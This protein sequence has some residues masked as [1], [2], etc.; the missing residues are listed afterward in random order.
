LRRRELCSTDFGGIAVASLRTEVCE[1]VRG[2]ENEP[3]AARIGFSSPETADPI[4]SAGSRAISGTA[5]YS[6]DLFL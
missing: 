3:P 6:Q 4:H 1:W 2:I 5:L